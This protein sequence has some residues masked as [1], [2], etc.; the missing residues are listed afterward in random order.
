MGY[1]SFHLLNE[2]IHQTL[3]LGLNRLM[4]EMNRINLHSGYFE[5][6]QYLFDTFH[7]SLHSTL[8][9]FCLICSESIRLLNES[10]HSVIPTRN[11]T[12][13]LLLY[14]NSPPLNS[15]FIESFATIH[16]RS[17]KL[18]VHK[19]FKIK[20]FFLESLCSLSHIDLLGC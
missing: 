2:S 16:S 10:I 17:Q 19:F 18:I 5:S 13:S 9:Q 12:L 20:H 14:I 7:S 11:F 1:S 6:I 3:W 8:F 15:T 4:L